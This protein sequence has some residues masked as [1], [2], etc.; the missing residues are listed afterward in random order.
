M[1]ISVIYNYLIIILLL[2]CKYEEYYLKIKIN[3]YLI[4]IINDKYINILKI[5]Y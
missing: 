1:N 3:K 2:L 4:I 5:F